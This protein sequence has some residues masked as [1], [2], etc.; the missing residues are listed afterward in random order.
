MMIYLPLHCERGTGYHTYQ[1]LW[2]SGV[3]LGVV[4]GKYVE[5]SMKR[6]YLLALLVCM[7]GLLVYQGIIHH[8]F[9]QRMRNR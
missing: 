7:V 9:M 4:L 1:L 5:D 8:Y 3:M 6:Q 2:E